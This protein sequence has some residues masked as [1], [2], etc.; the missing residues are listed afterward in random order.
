MIHVLSKL[1]ILMSANK[2]EIP[3]LFGTSG[4]RGIVG[5][6]LTHDMLLNVGKSIAAGLKPSAS[7]LVATD[8]RV[9]R[10]F[11]KAAVSMGL[12]SGGANVIDAGILPTPILA[13]ATV[14][15]GVDAGIMI[16]ASHNPPEYN[17]V[18]LF[19]TE[20]IGYSSRQENEIER[21]YAEKNFP[22]GISSNYKREN[23]IVSRYTQYLLKKFQ[24][25][26]KSSHF[27]IAVDPGNGAASGIA[28]KIFTAFGYTV[29]PINDTPDGTFPGR[30]PEPKKD[31]LENTW[32]FVKDNRLD[33]A[34]CFDGDDDRVVFVDQ[35]GFIGFTE[36][37][38]FIS[39]LAVKRSGKKKVAATVETGRLLDNALSGIG[40]EVVRGKVGDVPVAHLA[41]E[42]DAAIGIESIGVYIMPELGLYPNSIAAAL[43]LLSSVNDI[44]EIRE[45]F[46]K[47][48]SLYLGQSKIPCANENKEALKKAIITNPSVFGTGTANVLDGLRMDFGNSWILVRPSGTEPIFRIIAESPSEPETEKLLEN[49]EITLRKMAGK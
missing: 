30:S 40:V 9:S 41:R 32:Q 14:D 34:V 19:T 49:A 6:E 7:V 35:K 48:P 22:D 25:G 43:T 20:G 2:S 23:G 24:P 16:T 8:S 26:K 29:M 47:V 39:A 15:M 17:G 27:R 36:S 45:F 13:F 4:I 5:T 37:V 3:K 12:L 11:V 10:E 31:T 46:R 21:I 33:I 38:A 28:S 1:E 44:S 42:V 18:K